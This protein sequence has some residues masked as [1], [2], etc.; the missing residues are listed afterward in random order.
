[1]ICT[2]E[3]ANQRTYLES[4]L[5]EFKR[6]LI[7]A[8]NKMRILFM[9]YYLDEISFKDFFENQKN[10]ILG[11]IKGDVIKPV[12]LIPATKNKI[13]VIEIQSGNDIPY[14]ISDLKELTFL[15][16]EK[17]EIAF[18]AIFA[19]ESPISMEA[20]EGE[21]HNPVKRLFKLLSTEKKEILYIL[22]YAIII[23]FIS[24]VI[25]LG[26]QTTV[27]LILGGV[28]LVQCTYLI[29]AH[30]PGCFIKRRAASDSNQF[31]RVSSTQD[32]HKSLV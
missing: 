18:F 16:N 28:F 15:T 25:P 9:E 12:L 19:Y 3:E 30:Y 8:G 31:G 21:T 7:E 13:S 6:D 14:T 1:M 5:I 11:F 22:F 17:G 23:G 10:P 32:L 26:I 2:I 24:L 27:E 20:H 29:D 4:D